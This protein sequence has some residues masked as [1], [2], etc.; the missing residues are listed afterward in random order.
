MSK[1]FWITT[2]TA[3][4]FLG[5]TPSASP[6]AS[7][8]QQTEYRIAIGGL[9]V[10]R[11]VFSTRI[12]KTRYSISGR[13]NTS[14]LADLIADIRAE[15][16][17]SGTYAGGALKARNYDLTYSSGKKTRVYRVN[18]NGGRVVSNS[19]SPEPVRPE[20]WV[21]VTARHLR[22]VL[23][24]L[25]GLVF[26]EGKKVCPRSLPIFDGET[27]MDLVLAAKGTK[28]FKFD[29][30]AGEAMVCSVR[31]V[32]KGGYK[33]GR[34]DIEYLK[35]SSEMEIWFASAGKVRLMAPVFVRIPT[36]IGM[37]TISARKI[38]N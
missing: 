13:V 6:A 10:A 25:S 20:G 16:S 32:P 14:G 1:S 22:S 37:L 29:G 26:P 33:Q 23:D 38:S 2:A 35:R 19:I 11:A 28:P 7:L 21:P 24:P 27:R 30:Y 31:F 4:S 18:F 12:D 5:L 8:T 15:T 3:L 34:K 36:Q 17:V 9:P